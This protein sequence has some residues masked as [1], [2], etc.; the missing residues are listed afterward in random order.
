MKNLILVSHPII[1]HSLTRLRDKMTEPSAFRR[2]LHEISRLIAYEATRDLKADLVEIETPLAKMKSEKII[3][4]PVIISV[5]R[6]GNGML[7]GL[8]AMMPFAAAG[9]IGIYRDK[10]IKNTVEYYLKLPQNIKGKRIFLADPLLATGDTMVA[11]IDR[12]KQYDVGPITILCVLCS[13]EGLDRVFNFHP[14]VKIY[15]VSVEPEMND[16][17]YLVPGL[18]DAGDRLYK[19]Q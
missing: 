13:K 11:C 7:D 6:A 14:D 5:M 12:L 16:L 10:F 4:W 9:H 17:G 19:T 1:Q 18:G 15:A 2:K 8:L 3:D